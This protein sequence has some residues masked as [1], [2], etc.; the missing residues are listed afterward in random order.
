MIN[1]LTI[2]TDI[3][4]EYINRREEFIEYLKDKANYD[5]IKSTGIFEL[6]NGGIEIHKDRTGKQFSIFRKEKLP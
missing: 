5:K 3:L 6:K 2:P 1:L 4:E